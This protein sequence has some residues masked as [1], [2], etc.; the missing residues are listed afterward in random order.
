MSLKCKALKEIIRHLIPMDPELQKNL[1]IECI[2]DSITSPDNT[3]HKFFQSLDARRAWALASMTKSQCDDIFAIFKRP[4]P[5]ETTCRIRDVIRSLNNHGIITNEQ[6]YKFLDKIGMD[7]LIL[8]FFK[9]FPF[10]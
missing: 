6:K 7:P 10:H 9:F 8:L 5:H 3:I 4:N 1:M 2:L